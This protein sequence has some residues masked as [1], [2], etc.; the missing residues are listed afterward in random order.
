MLAID[1][2]SA[3]LNSWALCCAVRPSVNAR[4]KLA[5]TPWLRASSVF[6]S[7]R[8]VS[9]QGYT[10]PPVYTANVRSHG[11][12]AYVDNSVTANTTKW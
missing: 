4:E 2:S 12:R 10:R 9:M 8:C 5:I 6:A 1:A 11:K 3:L 7:S